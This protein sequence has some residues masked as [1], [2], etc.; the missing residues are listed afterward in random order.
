MFP[1]AIGNYW[2]YETHLTSDIYHSSNQTRDSMVIVGLSR[3]EDYRIA[4]I[5]YFSNGVLTANFEIYVSQHLFYVKSKVLYPFLPL[6]TSVCMSRSPDTVKPLIHFD[7]NSYSCRDTIAGDSYPSLVDDGAGG[8][9][10]V[11]SQT[12]H[13]LV[14]KCTKNG[15]MQTKVAAENISGIRYTI[16]FTHYY[17]ILKPDFIQMRTTPGCIYENNNRK[18]IANTGWLELS[19]ADGVGI[20]E[21]SGV[22][23][24]CDKVLWTHTRKLLKYEVH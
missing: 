15:P 9:T 11:E 3:Y 20:I 16:D 23:M 12:Q 21:T 4:K 10:T 1:A 19:L 14:Y 6:D 22:M 5:N 7:Y 8:Y 17:Y 2:V 18:V 24:R 13:E